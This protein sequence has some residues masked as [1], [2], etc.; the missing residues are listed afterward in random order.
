MHQTT[1]FSPSPPNSTT[2]DRATQPQT[3]ASPQP[4]LP[5]IPLPSKWTLN[6]RTSITVAAAA[7]RSRHTSH[8]H[9]APAPQSP[10]PATAARWSPVTAPQ[11]RAALPYLHSPL[12]PQ[13]TRS[14]GL[15]DLLPDTPLHL[16]TTPPLH[17]YILTATATAGP[18]HG[19]SVARDALFA[20]L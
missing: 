16:S 18:S 10:A 19:P 1:G 14:D 6:P 9:P 5:H 20:E 2:R 15:P 4:A 17:P 13:G 11:T 8:P 3:Q 12:R 7:T